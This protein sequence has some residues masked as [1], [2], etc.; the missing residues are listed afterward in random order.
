[1]K[2]KSKSFWVDC[3][4]RK[5]ILKTDFYKTVENYDKRYFLS[6]L[7]DASFFI[8]MGLILLLFEKIMEGVDFSAFSTFAANPSNV[9]ALSQMNNTLI[10]L[11][12][13]LLIFFILTTT[14]WSISRIL[15]YGQI[16][17]KKF[18]F[19]V[20][21]K[22]PLFNILTF[23][24]FLVFSL[25][26]SKLIVPSLIGFVVLIF[27]LMFIY[28]LN[29]YYIF[30][31]KELKFGKAFTKT[32]DMFGK[33]TWLAFLIILPFLVAIFILLMFALAIPGTYI[34]IIFFLLILGMVLT[35]TYL[36][37]SKFSSPLFV[38][39]AGIIIVGFITSLIG[40]FLALLNTTQN[41]TTNLIISYMDLAVY[42][43]GLAWLRFYTVSTVNK[44]EKK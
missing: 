1:M 28:L 30:Y 31:F 36:N 39:V 25:L 17:K 19:D 22:F 37:E 18:K 33:R 41:S 7:F 8:A 43:L 3:K 24:S 26:L 32:F 9:S 11:F 15:I 20:F 29:L 5:W 23:F 44:I 2:K 13:G 21:W 4:I 34:S 27:L 38:I 40:T 10:G 6:A 16:Y 35:L 42:L 14:I 12:W